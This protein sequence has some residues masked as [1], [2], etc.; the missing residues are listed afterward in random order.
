MLQRI[1]QIINSSTQV[2]EDGTLFCNNY[3]IADCDCLK[4]LEN[5]NILESNISTTQIGNTVNLELSLAELNSIGYYEDVI[6]FVLKNKY[7]MPN[8][9]YYI[10]EIKCY[11][12]D[13]NEFL[14]RYSNVISLINSIKNIAKHNYLDVDTDISII[15]S[16]D[17]ALLLSFIYN[18]A[19]I[20]QISQDNIKN[21]VEIFSNGN[22]KEQLIFINELIDFLTSENEN[23]RFKFL[24]SHIAEF[25]DRANNAYQYYIRNFSYN[26]L[27]TELDNA[28]LEYS[29]KI[30][31]VINDAQTKLIAIPAANV[32]AVSN[33]SFANLID[34]KNIV[35][36]ISLFV[37]AVLINIF[38]KNQK[39]ALKFTTHNINIYK[40]TFKFMDNIVKES[41][42][43]VDNELRKQKRRLI[44]IQC[45]NWGIPIL[46]LI[47]SIV[48]YFNWICQK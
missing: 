43:I 27:K 21:I 17:K 20:Q 47:I 30:Q 9:N 3:I 10:E 29:K 4:Y 41:F 24:L 32:L 42:E 36:I 35:L 31:S 22:S 6:T 5:K 37:F 8:G 38:I 25:A 16:E 1:V 23:N 48:V 33:M 18:A 28:A 14:N 45:I 46:L 12:T 2:I 11:N 39:S 15:F 44:I 34:I 26:K 7:T 40:Q 13:C 19:D